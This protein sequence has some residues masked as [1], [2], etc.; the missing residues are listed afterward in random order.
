M[1]DVARPTTERSRRQRARRSRDAGPA[2]P[3]FRPIRN[4]YRPFEIASAD[5]IEALHRASL[6][7]LKDIGMKVTD[8]RARDFLKKAGA[9][10][11]R[12]THMVRFD[13]GLIEEALSAIPSQFTVHARDPQKT[14]TVGGDAM[15]FATVCGPPFVCDLDR[16]RRDGTYED[17]CNFVKLVHSLNIFHHEGGAG[18]EPLDLPVASRHLDMMYAQITLTDKGWEPTWLNSR[19]RARDCI[20]MAKIAM[21][22]SEEELAERPAFCTGINTNSPLLLDGAMSDGLIEMALAGQPLQ[23]H[24]VHARRRHEPCVAC[25]LAGAAEC[26]GAGRLRAGASRAQGLP[27][28]LRPLHLQRRYAHRLARLRHAG[29]RQVGHHLRPAC[30]PLQGADSL[31][32]HHRLGHGRCPGGL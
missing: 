9:D 6:K 14:L 30:A 27:R 12:D 26:R 18:V 13:E 8:G 19:K 28:L 24:P 2:Q 31:L 32:Q 10:V 22:C 1:T 17:V 11:N 20:E 29:I 21:Q 23:R 5:Q 4:P 15:I 3:P 7:V 16:G 25:G